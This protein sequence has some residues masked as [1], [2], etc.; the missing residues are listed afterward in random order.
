MVTVPVTRATSWHMVQ[1][2]SNGCGKILIIMY[3]IVVAYFGDAES[4]RKKGTVE[5]G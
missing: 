4:E 3:D 2:E 5:H 1:T